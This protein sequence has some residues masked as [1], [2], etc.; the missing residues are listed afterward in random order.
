MGGSD[1]EDFFSC[2]SEKIVWISKTDFKRENPSLLE[3]T[4]GESRRTFE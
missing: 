2:I 4:L 3:L 1:G